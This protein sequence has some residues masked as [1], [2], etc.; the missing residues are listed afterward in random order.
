MKRI[1]SDTCIEIENNFKIEAGPGAGKTTWLINHIK[2]VLTTSKRLGVGKKIACITYTNNA[3]NEIKERLNEG[4]GK[5]EVDTIHGF[6][7]RNIIKPYGYLLKDDNGKC[8]INLDELSGHQEHIPYRNFLRLLLE[9]YTERKNNEKNYIFYLKNEKF[10]EYIKK[11]DWIQNEQGE[12]EYKVNSLNKRMIFQ[13]KLPSFNKEEIEEYKMNY[14]KIG[15]LHHEDVLYLSYKILKENNRIVDF[16]N[17]KFPYIFIDEFQDTHPIQAMIIKMLTND[18]T[19]IGI[20]GDSAQAIYEF[21]GTDRRQFTEFNVDNLKVYTIKEN[22][23]SGKSIVGFLNILRNDFEQQ[24]IKLNSG[25]VRILVGDKFK[26]V[27]KIRNEENAIIL[28]RNNSDVNELEFNESLI[29]NLWEKAI[30]I[31]SNEKRVNTLYTILK[32]IQLYNFQSYTEAR[33]EISKILKRRKNE[34][35][36]SK[37]DKRKIAIDILDKVA[38]S[39]EEYKNQ[40]IIDF[41][42]E[43]VKNIEDIYNL[44]KMT[45]IITSKS[46]RLVDFYKEY[47]VIDFYQSLK[48]NDSQ[49][50]IRT[51][52]SAKGSE[53]NSVLVIMDEKQK[54]YLF[55][56]DLEKE[57][58]RIFYV[59]FSRAKEKL[60]INVP[61]L[62]ESEA[63]YLI[64]RNIDIQYI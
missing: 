3:V 58:H 36:L 60:F 51:I 26:I 31:D 49:G 45:S 9:R 54:K 1:K 29:D 48:I 6:L 42:N 56:F 61:I 52:H 41:N 18:K 14:W 16:L 2:Q 35:K 39:F 24:P 13:N 28:V 22:N 47:K 10:I 7:Y 17:K 30:A 38:K 23:R 57:E 32:S 46:K 33:K 8:L 34:K 5:V 15:V 27:E 50:Y 11:F 55:N 63:E 21:N 12:F 4:T 19:R 62:N 43:V 44:G 37:W 59:A 53:F 40:G 64:K 20:I 25:E